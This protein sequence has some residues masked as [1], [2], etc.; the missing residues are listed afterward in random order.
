[1]TT[2]LAIRN[3]VTGYGELRIIRDL[4]LECETGEITALV[5]RNGAGKTTTL[6]A[7]AGLLPAVSGTVEMGDLVQ[8][9]PPGT[10][11]RAGLGVV[12]EGKRVFR[13]RTVEENLKLGGYIRRRERGYIEASIA[14]VFDRF[15]VLK[16]KRSQQ[17]GAL[18]GGQQQMLAIGQALMSEPRVLLLDEPS[19]GLAPVIVDEVV[20][21]V[22]V[23]KNQGMCVLLVEQLVDKSLAIAD[24]V[25]V[26]DRRRITLLGCTPRGLSGCGSRRDTVTHS[27]P[28]A[29][30]ATGTDER[31]SRYG[32]A[33]FHA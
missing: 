3:L 17:A 13:A 18:S 24:R 10:R 26:L 1:M 28:R 16:D 11:I 20:A 12:Q 32:A 25:A 7:V 30:P 4:S 14:R 27:S 29:V 22:E 19:A 9:G 33:S 8:H 5:G 15:P 6:S 23:L 2:G 31:S 21:Q